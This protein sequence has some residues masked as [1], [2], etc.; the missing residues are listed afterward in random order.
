MAFINTPLRYPGGKSSL[1]VFL[2]DLLEING[3]TGGVYVEPYAGGAGAAVNLLLEGQVERIVINDRDRAIY[4]FWVSMLEEPGQFARLVEET[5]VTVPEWRRQKNVFLNPE[6]F[7][8]LAV[9]FATFFLN[10][11]NHSGILKANPIGG[12]HQTG[13]YPIWAR[14]NKKD[15]L[16]RIERIVSLRD[17]IE[18]YNLDAAD[19]LNDV[20]SEIAVT[21]DVLVYLDPPYFEKGSQ[22]YLDYYTATDHAVLAETMRCLDT[23]AWAMTYDDVADIRALYPWANIT[24]FNLNYFAHKPKKGCELLIAP[25][26]LHLPERVVVHYGQGRATA[27]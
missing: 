16:A 3:L 26:R 10:R 17:R 22:L 12:I 4:Q 7:S 20:V 27:S 23:V 25:Q 1:S 11:C 8:D 9:G 2:T 14:F 13:R 6:R 5:P 19:L 21:H 15:L 18:V 24:N